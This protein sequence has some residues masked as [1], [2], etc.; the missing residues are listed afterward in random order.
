MS[1]LP[2]RECNA[3]WELPETLREGE[4]GDRARHPHLRRGRDRHLRVGRHTV[5]DQRGEV[6]MMPAMAVTTM[7]T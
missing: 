1:L 7:L 2:I 6:G 3:K 4:Q 5:N